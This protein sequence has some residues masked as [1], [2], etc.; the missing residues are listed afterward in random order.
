MRSCASS[1]GAPAEE[2]H[3]RMELSQEGFAVEFAPTP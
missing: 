3:E 1:A 2:A